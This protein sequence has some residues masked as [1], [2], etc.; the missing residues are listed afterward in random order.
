MSFLKINK[1]LVTKDGKSVYQ[2]NFHNGINIIRG[3]NSSGKSTISNFIFFGLGGE[4]I[5]W[6]P[7]AG[8]CDFVFVEVELND[9]V[10]TLKRQIESKQ[11]RPMMI[12]WGELNKA[13]VSNFEGWNIYSY[14]RTEKTESFSQIL[15]KT[16]NFPEVS[17]D[18]LES[19][20]FNQV[21]RLLYIDQLS[22]LDC[23]MKNED[24]DS[25]LI[26]S[27]I[28]N[29]LLGTY[30]DKLLKLQMELRHK[31]KE[32]SE[33]KKQVHAIEDVF[34][35]SPFEFNKDTINDKIKEK[36]ELLSKT[37]TVLKNPSQ[38]VDSIKS[39]D[40]K[41]EIQL[42]RKNLN[43]F[44]INFDTILSNIGNNKIDIIDNN[45]FIEVLNMKLKA[46]IESLNSREILGNFPILYCPICLEKIEEN[47]ADN[48]CKLCKKEITENLGKSKLLRMKVEV[49]MQIKESTEILNEK[50]EKV[51][52]LEK[53]LK[54]SERLLKKAQNDIDIYINNSRSS[55]ENKFDKLLENKGK[56]NA[57]IEFF[58]KQLQLIYSYDEYKIQMFALKSGVDRLNH[59]T[60]RLE[61]LQRTKGTKAYSVIQKYALQLLKGDG[62]Y[63]EKFKDGR[64]VTV[65]F[66]RNTFFLDNRNRF[67]ASS[68]VLLKN[69][70]R[71]AIFFASLNLDYFR[72]PKFIICDNVEDK[73]MV[74]ERS[75]NFQK[76]VVEIASSDDFKDKEF[77][78][79]MT[80][81]MIA[82]ELNIPKYTIGAFYDKHNKTLKFNE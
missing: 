55:T 63:E 39:G 62:E 7:E 30:D 17:T 28:G 2:E 10:I 24:F 58:E 75:K 59:E 29:L 78:I 8:N 73:G 31:E 42:L 71:F 9:V 16:L 65:D 5:D 13:I 1:L 21:L 74:E 25:P 41:N 34:K 49:E 44:K 43:N 4:F 14:K 19:I 22:A 57:E 80:T 70:V 51:I 15:F 69:S 32:L 38:I 45:E 3:D 72:F 76:K 40:T 64:Q 6:L 52:E 11:M 48:H 47:L 27:A 36:R 23:L 12:Y 79:I 26:R 46:I 35:N 54:D 50:Q 33:I 67:S 37:I 77:Q 66:A 53:E 18:N 61:E 81:S 20:T 68:M 60:N 56:L 82:E